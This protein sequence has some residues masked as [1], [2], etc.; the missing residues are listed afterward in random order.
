M[1]FVVLGEYLVEFIEIK[2]FVVVCLV[3]YVN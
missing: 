3:I 1:S 2:S